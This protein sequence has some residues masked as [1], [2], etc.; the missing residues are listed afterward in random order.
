MIY[1]NTDCDFFLVVFAYI[2]YHFHL[3]SKYFFFEGV[4]EAPKLMISCILKV[5]TV[6]PILHFARV[7]KIYMKFIIMKG[8]PGQL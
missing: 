6:K 4:G 8:L 2:T 5:G 1:S 3:L 7:K